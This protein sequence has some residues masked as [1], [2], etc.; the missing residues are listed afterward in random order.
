MT[1]EITPTFVHDC[2]R[3]TFLGHERRHDLYFCTQGGIAKTI[4]ARY[5]DDGP[6]YMSGLGLVDLEPVLMVAKQLAIKRGL[7]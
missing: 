6:E 3:C 4:I 2:E 5:G 1:S 7:L